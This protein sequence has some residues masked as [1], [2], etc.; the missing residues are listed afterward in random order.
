MI[1]SSSSRAAL[2]LPSSSWKEKTVR[3]LRPCTL[4]SMTTWRSFLPADAGHEPCR[5]LRRTNLETV[6]LSFS[7]ASGHT[8]ATSVNVRNA[9]GNLLPNDTCLTASC[10][11][12][13]MV[14]WSSQ[15]SATSERTACLATSQESC[16]HIPLTVA[17]QASLSRRSVICSPETAIVLSTV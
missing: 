8:R 14:P 17:M 12:L 1:S 15:P 4:E 16:M 10:D 7:T 3:S 5:S 2:P 9:D 13:L 11:I 6:S